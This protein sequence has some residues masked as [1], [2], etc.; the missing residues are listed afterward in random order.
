MQRALEAALAELVLGVELDANDPAAVAAWL[1]RHQVAGADAEALKSGELGR[2]L[3]YRDLVRST[4]RDAVELAVPRAMAR[5]GALFDL[6]FAGFLAERGPRSH[7]LRD[8]TDEF[9][10]HALPRLLLDERVPGYIP[11][12]LRFEALHIRVAAAPPLTA[13]REFT[14]LEL[15][16]GLYF[17]ESVRLERFEHAVHELSED[18]DDRREPRRV[19][20][21]LLI[22]RSPDHIV[23]YLELSPLA[24]DILEPLLAG[25]SLRESL[26]SAGSRQNVELADSVLTGTAE[27][28]ADLS[29]RGAL[30]GPRA[31]SARYSS[32]SPDPSSLSP[33]S[34]RLDTNHD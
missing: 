1:A 19:A 14:E 13:P 5:L 9:I 34:S 20:T 7:Y 16:A 23:R 31:V 4:L 33:P 26:I 10:E 2:M 25:A 3:V 29:Q 18:L 21:R 32:S 27:L 22:Y 8:V 30:L 24:A 28:L 6:Y 11:E 17:S 12:L 15:D